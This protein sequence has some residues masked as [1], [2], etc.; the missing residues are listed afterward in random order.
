MTIRSIVDLLADADTNLPDNTTQLISAAD[1]RNLIKDFL[2][3]MSPAYGAIETGSVPLV[4]TPTPQLLAPYAVD[5][6]ATSGY[7]VNNLSA[8]SVQRLLNAAGTT[9]FI[10]ASGGVSGPNN[11]NVTVTLFKNGAATPYAASVTC[12][13]AGDIVGF[14]IAGIDYST[15]AATYELRVSAPAGSH[16][17]SGVNLLVQAQPVR[18]FV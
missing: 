11:S 5:L 13:G 7:F 2:D 6:A 16:T 8:G 3:T 18:S 14:N 1:V 4:L 12:T 10:I 9:N 17:F 15:V